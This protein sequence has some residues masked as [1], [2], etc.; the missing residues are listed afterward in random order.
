MTPP[1]IAAAAA[2]WGLE[3]LA[4]PA[5]LRAAAAD[6]PTGVEQAEAGA[7]EGGCVFADAESGV[8][9]SVWARRRPADPLG[10]YPYPCPGPGSSVDP[11]GR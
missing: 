11:P 7:E 4:R 3:R 8:E 2:A 1:D 5:W 6:Q 10:P 9:V